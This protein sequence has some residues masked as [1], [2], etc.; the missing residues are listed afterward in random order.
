MKY[1]KGDRIV[2]VNESGIY[3]GGTAGDDYNAKIG[4]VATIVNDGANWGTWY[5]D[6]RVGVAYEGMKNSMNVWIGE[7]FV[8]E[9]FYNSP[10]YSEL[11]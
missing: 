4:Q 9:S 10:L 7:N 5:T 6:G 2:R 3:A 1:K 11:R 8:L